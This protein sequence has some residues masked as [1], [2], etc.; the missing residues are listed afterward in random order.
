MRALCAALFKEIPV[1]EVGNIDF[2]DFAE[3]MLGSPSRSV[4]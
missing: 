1:V 4:Q 3:G 2:A